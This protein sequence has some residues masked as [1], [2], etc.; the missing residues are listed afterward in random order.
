[1]HLQ[2][3][4]AQ[5]TQMQNLDTDLCEKI[6][7]EIA[8][9]DTSSLQTAAFLSLLRAKSETS[10]ELFGM[11]KGLRN[12]MIPVKT[13]HKILDLVG[14]GGDR[15]KTV[16]ISTGSA[17]LAA[18]CGVKI[19]KH[20]SR[21]VSSL[22]GSA[23]VLEALGIVIN[24]SP[25]QVSASIDEIGIGFC[26]APHFHPTMLKLRPLRRELGFPTSLNFLG[27]LL[28]PA[29]ADHYVLGVY[30]KTMMI[31]MAE[32][33]KKLGTSHSVIVHGAGLDELSCIGP[34]TIVEINENQIH[35][36]TLN[37]AEFGFEICSLVD[38]QGGDGKQNAEILINALQGNKSAVADTL[39]LN[40]A[41]ALFI[42]G[43][44]PNLADSISYAK[45]V[46]F[47]G[48]AMKLLNRWK[49]FSHDQSA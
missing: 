26:H 44:Y 21:A 37:P 8:K 4:I 28:N 9:D 29:N 36:S 25:E 13:K 15:T 33:L 14:T 48:Q 20:G 18:S 2:A 7:E 45:D 39:I 5:L 12:M 49:E 42:Y 22:A 6:I 43:L 27:P 32:V 38:L 11:V 47:S 10:D 1:M 31:R 3:G 40:A 19:A 16:N 23:D 41:M 46:L 34:A 30:D 35:A 24:L 17:I